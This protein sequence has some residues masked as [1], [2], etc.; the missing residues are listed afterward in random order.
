M[1]DLNFEQVREEWMDAKEQKRGKQE[2]I[3]EREKNERE[4]ERDVK[5]GKRRPGGSSGL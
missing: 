4:R 2:K 5:N 3:A 1:K